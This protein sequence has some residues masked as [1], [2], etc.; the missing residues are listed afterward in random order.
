MKK[1]TVMLVPH[2]RGGTQTLVL[3]SLHFWV[4]VLVLGSLTFCSAFFYARHHKLA[5]QNLA[6][7]RNNRVLELENARKP[8]IIHRDAGLADEELQRIEE[9]LR[10]EYEAS[11]AGITAE[12]SEL[13]DM[14]AKARSITG[15]APRSPSEVRE[16]IP[17]GDGK[18][19]MPSGQGVFAYS[20]ID[21]SMRP[22]H[23]VYGMSR[24][25]ADLILQEIQLRTQSFR[26]LVH[27][28]EVEIDR[29]ERVPSIWPLAGH[30]GRI[31][32]GFGYRRDPITYRVRHHDGTDIAANYGTK[33]R[34]TAKGVVKKSFYDRQ[35]HGDVVRALGQ[36]AC[37][38][39]RNGRP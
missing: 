39:R 22:P 13:Y 38:A 6:L 5:S 33:V 2:D 21:E 17:T 26:E 9:R 35:R 19:G 3:S 34:A 7:R 23:V 18:G 11:I 20:G 16:P 36:A 14:E 24:P 32:S 30:A 27:D 10:S 15:L 4:V 1:W 25:S 28:M 8:Q 31:S 29:I 12:L 37:R